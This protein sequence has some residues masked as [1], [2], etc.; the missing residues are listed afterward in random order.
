M[1]IKITTFLLQRLL[2]FSHHYKIN[3]FSQCSELAVELVGTVAYT[4]RQTPVVSIVVVSRPCRCR[5]AV[6]TAVYATTALHATTISCSS[7]QSNNNFEVGLPS[8]RVL[9]CS[10]LHYTYSTQQLVH[11]QL[12][13]FHCSFT[14]LYEKFAKQVLRLLL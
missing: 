9:F 11:A 14:R 12:H 2:H 1:L 10:L 5:H 7:S 3:I 6:N 13:T 8:H 4:H